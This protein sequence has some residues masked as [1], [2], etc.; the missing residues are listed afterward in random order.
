VARDSDAQAVDQ[1]FLSLE[2]LLWGEQVQGQVT[3]WGRVDGEDASGSLLIRDIEVQ[4]VAC[5]DRVNQGLQLR[6][7]GA[8]EIPSINY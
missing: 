4:A 7:A 8:T 3:S 2:R 5:R 6:G 1:E